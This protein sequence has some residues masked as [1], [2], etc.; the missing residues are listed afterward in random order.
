MKPVID[1]LLDG[2]HGPEAAELMPMSTMSVPTWVMTGPP[3]S[4]EQMPVVD[5]CVAAN[6]PGQG[7][8]E[9]SG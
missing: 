7:V 2:E 9:V 6:D 4:P 1:G 5:V 8:L 3:E